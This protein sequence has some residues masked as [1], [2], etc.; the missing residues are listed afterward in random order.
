MNHPN[1]SASLNPGPS[2]VSD[3]EPDAPVR[4]M[5]GC[6]TSTLKAVVT[7]TSTPLLAAAVFRPEL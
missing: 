4:F 3:Q 5:W 7:A 2:A 6:S 1:A